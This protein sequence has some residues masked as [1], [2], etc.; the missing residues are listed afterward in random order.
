MVDRLTESERSA[1]LSKLP[2]WEPVK[3]RD[4]IRQARIR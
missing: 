4:A 3:D 2:K 1:A